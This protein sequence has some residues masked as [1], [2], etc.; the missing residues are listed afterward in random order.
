MGLL[1]A[2]DIIVWIS[3]R[4][5]REISSWNLRYWFA[6]KED[7]RRAACVQWKIMS[8]S[9]FAEVPLDVTAGISKLDAGTQLTQSAQRIGV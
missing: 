9:L 8:T 2:S 6:G 3:G 4:I 1:A 7:S 5:S